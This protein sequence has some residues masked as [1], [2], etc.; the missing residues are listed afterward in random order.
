MIRRAL[1]LLFA[2][3]AGARAG[4]AYAT[5]THQELIDLAWNGGIRPLLL[6]RYPGTSEASLREAHGFAYGG[7]LIQ[8][9]GYY[10]FGEELFSNLTHYVRSGDFVT[11]L[12]RDA[13]NVNELAFAIGALSHYVGDSIGHAEAVNPATAITFP[14]LRKRYGPIV[15]YEEQPIAHVRVEFGFDLAQL[16][17]RRYAPRAYRKHIG[18]HVPR[19]LLARAYFET[20]GLRLRGILGPPRPAVVSYR[21]SVRGIIPLF[22]GATGFNVRHRLPPDDSGPALPPL[23]ADIARTDYA[24]YWGAY[25]RGPSV[26]A[27]LLGYV[28]RVVP[29]IGALKILDI[30]APS[31]R[32]EALFLAS[33]DHALARFRDLLARLAA[34][35]PGTLQLADRDLDTGSPVMPGAYRLTDRTYATL[36]HKL[37]RKPGTWIPPR[38]RANI[39]RYYADPAA[40]ISTKQNAKAWRRVQRELELL[41][42]S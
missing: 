13:A 23:L 39:L 2:L 28:F 15:T 17:R 22:A 30:K 25:Y 32:T 41:K 20:Y 11:A 24:R 16:D 31:P 6:A 37:T 42:A 7:C 4:A 12:L 33:L 5:F 18:F 21:A 34:A 8:D 10:P 26:G 19:A 1:P 27:R 3:L 38:V 40:P 35:P 14:D 9:L 29:K 36:L